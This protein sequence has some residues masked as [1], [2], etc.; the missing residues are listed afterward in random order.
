MNDIAST[1]TRDD[2]AFGGLDCFDVAADV[3]SILL[4]GAFLGLAHPVFDLGEALLDQIEF[5]RV[6]RQIPEPRAHGP[7]HLPDGRPARHRRGSIGH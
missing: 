3:S 6:G 5:R 7:D 4:D 1:R 2:A